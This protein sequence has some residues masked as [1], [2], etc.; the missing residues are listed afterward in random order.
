MTCISGVVIL[1]M[2][3]LSALASNATDD[4]ARLWLTGVGQLELPSDVGGSLL[5]QTRFTDDLSDFER[6]LVNPS[7]GHRLGA[8]FAA[9]IGYDAHIIRSPRRRI[10]HRSWQQLGFR[11]GLASATILHR[12]RVE[13]RFL[14]SVDGVA[15]RQRYMLRGSIGLPSTEWQAVLSN[16][17]FLD[18]NSP[19]RGPESGFGETRLFIGGD[20]PIGKSTT[21]QIGYQ[22][23]FVDRRSEDLAAHTVFVSIAYGP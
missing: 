20:H 2:T 7:L 14:E 19:R 13:E 16:E 1:L 8:G 18:L 5:L 17:I 4:D 21:L 15:L 11:H 3:L 12:M 10:E 23:Q 6:L 22:L 9:A